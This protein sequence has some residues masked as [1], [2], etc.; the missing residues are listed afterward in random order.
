MS[1]FQSINMPECTVQLWY[2]KQCVK[3][4]GNASLYLQI[5]ICGEHQEVRLKRLQWI[6]QN[7]A[8]VA[9]RFTNVQSV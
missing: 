3:R 2:N 1:N 6:E 9:A 5:M 4:N 8:G 7:L